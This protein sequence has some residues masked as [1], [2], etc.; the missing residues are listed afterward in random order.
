MSPFYYCILKGERA[1]QMTIHRQTGF[2]VALYD[3]LCSV[4]VSPH[5]HV[6]PSPI[7]EVLTSEKNQPE[8]RNESGSSSLPP[9]IIMEDPIN[10][11]PTRH[12]HGRMDAAEAAG[13]VV[14]NWRRLSTRSLTLHPSL[15]IP[16][17]L[18][19]RNAFHSRI[20]LPHNKY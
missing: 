9:R 2:T 20:S 15:S 17:A 13:S 19:R 16:L 8:R 14:G 6:H 3:L 7:N 12:P 10:H 18:M 4:V 5:P 11:S 1:I